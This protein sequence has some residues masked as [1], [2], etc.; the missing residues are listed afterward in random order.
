VSD[1]NFSSVRGVAQWDDRAI[2]GRG[3]ADELGQRAELFVANEIGRRAWRVVKAR[4][5]S[6]L[7]IGD[8]RGNVLHLQVK[9]ARSADREKTRFRTIGTE[10]ADIVVLVRM[11]E[12]GIPADTW[13]VPGDEL[14]TRER[15]GLVYGGQLEAFHDRWDPLD[16]DA[17]R[18]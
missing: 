9:A 3:A 14:R 6:D 15:A 7:V 10:R 13:V 17:A 8:D 18:K 12:S 4:G 11:D 16:E 5:P 1:D 2:G